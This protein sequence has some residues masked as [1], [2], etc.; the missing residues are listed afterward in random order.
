MLNRDPARWPRLLTALVVLALLVPSAA[1]TR[2]DPFALFQPETLSTLAGFVA[3]FFPPATGA[4]FLAEVAKETLTTVAVASVGLALAMAIGAPVAFAVSRGLDA[5]RL[6]GERA[7]PLAEGGKSALR[8]AMVLLRGVPEIVWAL[9]FVRAAGLGSLPAVLAIGLAYGGMLGKVYAEIVESQPAQP[10]RALAAQGAGRFVRFAWGV[11]PQALPELISYTVY[12]WEC[13][14][15][16]SAVMGFVGAGGIGQLLDT[17]IKMM[18]G[19]EVS[20]LLIVF[21]LLVLMTETVSRFARRAS[22]SRAGLAVVVSAMLALFVAS[23]AWLAPGWQGFEF[24][25]LPRFAAEFFPPDTDAATLAELARGTLETLA[26]SLLGSAIAFFGGALLAVPAAGRFG[27]PARAAARLL[28]NLLRGVPDLMWAA[29]AVL[30]VGLGP[31]AGVLALA[32]HTSGV[33]GRLFA[34]TLE[35]APREP[36]TALVALGAGRVAAFVHGLLPQVIAQWLAYTLYR[37]ENNIRIAAVLGIVGAGG[38]G[39]QLYLALSLFQ[40]QAAASVIVA[41]LLLSWGVEQISRA[42]RRRLEA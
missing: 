26:I 3:G 1:Y 18:N 28:L 33:L 38:L 22:E 34:E 12:R 37:W 24:A 42:V 41:M 21:L 23:V 6:S 16:A 35:N 30:A 2:F 25:A 17:S 11:W 19:G 15:R 36:E 10:A 20:T 13:A 29:L 14:I 39:Q 5:H 40:Q 9:L 4:A 27:A 7:R 31:A 8:A 32:L